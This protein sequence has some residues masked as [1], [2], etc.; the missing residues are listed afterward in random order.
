MSDRFRR[1]AALV[2]A[3]AAVACGEEQLPPEGQ[4]ILHVT[5]DAPVPPAFGAPQSQ[6]VSLFD[7]LSVEVFAGGASEPCGACSRE[8]EID[9]AMIDEGRASVGIVPPAGDHGVRVRI[10]LFRAA[11]D[12]PA[13][14]A[15]ST[16]ES[17]VLI[18]PAPDEGV[19]HLTVTLRTEN[20]GRPEGTIEAP[21]QPQRGEPVAGL[22]GTWPGSAR[23]DCA[24][25]AGPDEVCVP[26]GPFWMGDPRL[27]LA[28][29]PEHQGANE[30]LVVLSPFFLDRTEVTVGALREAG[31]A[32]RK[33]GEVFNPQPAA[34]GDDFCTYRDE[35]GPHDALPVNCITWQLASTYCEKLGK[36]LP[37]EAEL[38]YA[39]SAM[40]TSR[41]PWGEEQPGCADAVFERAHDDGVCAQA[42]LGPAA[43]GSGAKD[44]WPV[45]SG[46]VH[47][48]AGNVMELAYDFWQLDSEP[49]WAGAGVLRD[50]RCE[51]PSTVDLVGHAVR[52][53]AFSDPPAFLQAAL[54]AGMAGGTKAV[55]DRVGFRCARDG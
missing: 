48:L 53:G 5:T 11:L 24:S 37:T 10:R 42:G 50:P 36:R 23:E 26:G 22:V 45:S 41:Y 9:A 20:V 30:R 35:A 46:E 19:E 49:C 18:P 15:T 38:G 25:A 21:V 1:W 6:T 39:A 54:R 2:G 13:P 31:V 55:N 43:V 51:L 40:G 28:G 4:F 8:F 3:A 33:D 32:E 14:R 17:V 52:G 29:A 12:A 47:D 34:P 44:R 27:D 16:L 7:R